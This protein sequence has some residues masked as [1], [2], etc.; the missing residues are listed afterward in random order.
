MPSTPL[1]IDSPDPGTLHLSLPPRLDIATTGDAWRRASAALD[2]PDIRTLRV[3]ATDLEN[4]DGAGI[5]L[6]VHLRDLSQA[7]GIAFEL[8]ALPGRFQPLLDAFPPGSLPPPLKSAEPPGFLEQIGRSGAGLGRDLRDLLGFTGELATAIGRSLLHPREIRWSE[9]WSTVERAGVNAFPIIALVGFLIGFILA[10]QSAVPMQQFGAEIFVADL[11]ALSLLRELGPLMTAIVL[12]GRSGSAFAAE[13]GTMKV[14]EEL[15]ALNTMGIRPLRFLVVPRALAAIIVTPILAAFT[16]FFG[17]IGGL[18]V[19]LSL[20][21][22]L[23]TYVNQVRGALSPEDFPSGL[24][25][26]L[27]FGLLVAGIGCLRGLQTGT[28][29]SAVGESTTRA[30]VAGIL[31]IILSDGLFSVVFYSLGI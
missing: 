10:F 11:V 6:L 28:G 3:A 17:L 14:K 16:S 12:A 21:F 13:I 29:A 23:V 4:I 25:K 24:A 9:T 22:P 8:A 18:V 1:R 26:A 31:L 27:V 19:M 5:G 15:D 20:G 2:R 7:R 30:V